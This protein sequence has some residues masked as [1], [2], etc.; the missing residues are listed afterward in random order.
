MPSLPREMTAYD[1][2]ELAQALVS[3][4]GDALFLLDP[5][6]EQLLEVNPVVLRLTGFPRSEVLQLPATYL[7]RMETGGGTQRL[8]GAFTKT[9]VFHGQDGYLLRTKSDGWVAVSLTIS[10]LHLT[11]KPLGLIIA[12]DDRDRRAALAQAK[13]VEAELRAVLA[14]SPSALWSAERAAPPPSDP[15]AG[16][17]FRYVS[18][19]L[20]GI[21]RRPPEFF[22]SPFKWAEVIHHADRDGYRAALRRLLAGGGAEAEQLYRVQV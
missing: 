9:G 15:F 22:D 5:D 1:P 17:Q 2:A 20:A 16:W 7:F 19:L 18:P 11:P 8:K 3:E 10:R 13:R 4:I 14:S 12:R 21:A 6:T